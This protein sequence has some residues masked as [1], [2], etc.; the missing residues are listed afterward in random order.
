MDSFAVWKSSST[1]TYKWAYATL[2][3]WHKAG[4]I[5]VTKWERRP[6][7]GKPRPFYRWGKGEDAPPIAPIPDAIKHQRYMKKLRDD[8]ARLAAHH[9]RRA[10]RE[11]KTPKLDP[12][13][14]AMLG[15]RRHGKAWIKPN[16]Q[17]PARPDHQAA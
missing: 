3:R 12:I 16:E 2:S 15:Y 1:G 4:L 14:A 11:R 7:G 10:L 17:E 8:P 9:D 5:H 13:H 6:D